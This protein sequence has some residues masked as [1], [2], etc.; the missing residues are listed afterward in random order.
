[1]T[2]RIAKTRNARTAHSSL[3]K[4]IKKLEEEFGG[5]LFHRERNHTILTELGRRVKPHIEMVPL[6]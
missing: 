5:P 3:T 6:F 1:M 2:E 4:A